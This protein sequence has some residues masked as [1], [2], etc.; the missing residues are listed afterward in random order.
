[1]AAFI[2]VIYFTICNYP[3]ITTVQRDRSPKLDMRSVRYVTAIYGHRVCMGRS[4]AVNNSKI[5]TIFQE[6]EAYPASAAVYL[7]LVV[8]LS[9]FGPV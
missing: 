4:L 6:K 5:C 1:M 2:I 9:R 8:F 7:C 3:N